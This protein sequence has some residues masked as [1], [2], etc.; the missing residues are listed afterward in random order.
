MTIAAYFG[1]YEIVE[2]LLNHQADINARD[3]DGDTAFDNATNKRHYKVVDLLK[4]FSQK[5]KE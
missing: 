1:H 3:N 2:M 5:E 4:K